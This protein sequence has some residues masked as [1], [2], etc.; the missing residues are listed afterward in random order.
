MQPPAGRVAA[1][2]RASRGIGRA[3]A[4]VLAGQVV[5]VNGGFLM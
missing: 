1:I 2:T 5:R 3:V 4:I